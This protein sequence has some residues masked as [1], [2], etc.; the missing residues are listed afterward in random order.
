M[1]NSKES[2][3]NLWN[4][5]GFLE[6]FF[7]PLMLMIVV[8]LSTGIWKYCT[9]KRFKIIITH[10]ASEIKNV[11]NCFYEVIR[12]RMLNE[13]HEAISV[14]FSSH[15]KFEVVSSLPTISDGDE[16]IDGGCRNIIFPI[17]DYVIDNDEIAEENTNIAPNSEISKKLV[18]NIG[19]GKNV[20]KYVEYRYGE[21]TRRIKLN[22]ISK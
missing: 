11:D 14:T 17:I 7:W 15:P 8:A 4:S 19:D 6:A 3:V 20:V 2:L 9:R 5:N 13:T 21:K 10:G 12:L 1:L 18:F 22:A 16:I